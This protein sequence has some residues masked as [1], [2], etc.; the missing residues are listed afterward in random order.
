MSRLLT[1]LIAAVFA[2]A[3]MTSFAIAAAPKG[4]APKAE[5]KKKADKAKK[6]AKPKKKTKKADKK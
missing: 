2:A 3:S 1:T 6:P 5:V 4:D